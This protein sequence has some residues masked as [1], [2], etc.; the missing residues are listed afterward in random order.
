MYPRRPP[1]QLHH[2]ACFA[3]WLAA[4]VSRHP[5]CPDAHC[6]PTPAM[7]RHP[8]CPDAHPVLTPVSQ[9][10]GSRE[11]RTAL[12]TQTRACTSKTGKREMRVQEK[13]VRL[14][15]AASSARF[16]PTE[17]CSRQGWRG[18]AA[19]L[20]AEPSPC[21]VETPAPEARWLFSHILLLHHP[22]WLKQPCTAMMLCHS[23]LLSGTVF[24]FTW[25]I[26]SF[27]RTGY[28]PA[29]CTHNAPHK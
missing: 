12:H 2:R 3:G 11:P 15:V 29:I 20:E 23:V 13:R 17:L 7:S 28:C 21:G 14:M 10:E 9:G 1:V 25:L 8:L 19:R 22:G 4:A 24:F 27:P 18:A 5:P 6:V 26:D 16:S